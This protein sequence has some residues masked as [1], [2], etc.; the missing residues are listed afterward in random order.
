MLFLITCSYTALFDHNVVNPH[1]P[2]NQ[3]IVKKKIILKRIV[4]LCILKKPL[5]LL[6]TK[7]FSFIILSQKMTFYPQNSPIIF[8]KF[9]LSNQ[10]TQWYTF[11]FSVMPACPRNGLPGKYLYVILSFVHVTNVGVEK[12][13]FNN[14]PPISFMLILRLY[15]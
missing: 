8:C 12:E 3:Q 11:F 9:L 2:N 7:L 13:V 6:L 5:K 10:Y 1:Q 4:P 15:V 14:L